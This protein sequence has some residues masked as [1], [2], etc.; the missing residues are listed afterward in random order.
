MGTSSPAAAWRGHGAW[1]RD[2]TGPVEQ[3]RA[4]LPQYSVETAC[5][6]LIRTGEDVPLAVDLLLSLG[7]T[8]ASAVRGLAS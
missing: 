2:L 6:A 3:I 8:E 1:S 4:A 7:T 5:E